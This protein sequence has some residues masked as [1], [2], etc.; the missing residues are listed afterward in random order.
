M[1]VV[2]FGYIDNLWAKRFHTYSKSLEVLGHLGL[3]DK[4][5]ISIN[6]HDEYTQPIKIEVEFEG[7][8]PINYGTL[9]DIAREKLRGK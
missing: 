5:V 6:K 8:P 4:I 1:K 3:S 7:E 9:N 2:L